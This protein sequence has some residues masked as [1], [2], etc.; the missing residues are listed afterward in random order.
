MSRSFGRV[1]HAGMKPFPNY[2]QFIRIDY[3]KA[4]LHGFPY[5]WAEKKYWDVERGLLPLDFITP[6]L[7]KYNTLR[8]N[9]IQ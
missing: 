5:L 9:V 3:M 1:A 6:F 7:E 4:L 8:K 2:A